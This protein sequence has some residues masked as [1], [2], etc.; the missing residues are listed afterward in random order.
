MV[1][2]R[3]KGFFGGLYKVAEFVTFFCLCVF[4]LFGAGRCAEAKYLY[5]VKYKAEVFGYADRYGLPRALV[6]AVIKTES[7]FNPSARSAAGA[8][9]L[10]QITEETGR[11]IAEKLGA[12]SYD[13][14]EPETNVAFGC[15]Y[16]KYLLTR[17][18][19][20]DTALAAYNAGEGNVALWLADERYS[21][22]GKSLAY[23]PF[24]ETRAYLRK[25]WKSFEK[26]K[27][28]YGKTLDK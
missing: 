4:C 24:P 13:L 8:A 19:K 1:K 16:I 23:V 17:F 26:Y 21:K 7:G 10:M 22:D 12:V 6:F 18:E 28:L 9:G 27:K 5:P 25:I 11:F 2:G 14:F 15:F 20:T 3:G